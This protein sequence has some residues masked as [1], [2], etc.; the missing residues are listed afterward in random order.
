[1]QKLSMVMLAEMVHPVIHNMTE[2]AI[3]S[4]AD[5]VSGNWELVCYVHGKWRF[6][7]SKHI[8]GVRVVHND[9]QLSIA[10]GYNEAVKLASGDVL[11]ILHNDVV[12]FCDGWNEVMEYVA[13]RGDV[14]FPMIDESKGDCELRGVPKTEPWQ[15]SSC[16]YMLTR[17][18]WDGLGGMDERFKGMH[19]EDIDLFRRCQSAGR[20]LVRCDPVVIHHRGVSRSFVP[21]RANK[22]FFKNWQWYNEKHGI[23]PGTAS[24]PRLSETPD[25]TKEEMQQCL[26]SRAVN[27]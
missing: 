18:A 27:C 3:E 21:D 1:M 14:A 8:P 9:S 7:L 4:A 17:N 11:C 5:T 24:L 15:T 10:K 12:F 25:V 2:L 16:C 20:R 13:R 23:K 6:D 26:E 22:P 19:G